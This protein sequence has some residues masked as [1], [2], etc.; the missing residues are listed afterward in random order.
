M[1]DIGFDM[2][3]EEWFDFKIPR[4]S[5]NRNFIQN[6]LQTEEPFMSKASAKVIWLGGLPLVSSYTKKKK[7]QMREIFEMSFHR[8]TDV[9]D[10]S[11]EKEYGEWF[12]DILDRLSINEEEVFTFA[13]LKENFEEQ[14]ENFELFWY[15]KPMLILRANGLLMV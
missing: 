14:F 15:S 3:L 5:I 6:C 2:P 8:K 10:V 13:T 1:H 4:S 11:M 9:V 7:G 12:L